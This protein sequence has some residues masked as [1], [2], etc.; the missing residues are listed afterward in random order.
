[1]PDPPLRVV[2]D[3]GWPSL[4]EAAAVGHVVTLEGVVTALPPDVVSTSTSVAPLLLRVAAV[5]EL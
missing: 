5:R 2:E 1:M 3:S 4:M